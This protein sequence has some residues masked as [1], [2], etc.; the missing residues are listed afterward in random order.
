[1]RTHPLAARLL[2]GG[3]GILFLAGCGG[4]ERPPLG[5]VSG[6]VTMDG[7]PLGNVIVVMKP[8]NGRAAMVQADEQGHYDME[9][10]AGERG[11]K[12]GPTTVSFEWPLDY[13]APKPIPEKYSAIRS[14]E[15]I[16]VKEGENTFDFD[17]KSD[18]SSSAQTPAE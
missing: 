16:E 6:T 5:Y 8:D 2:V 13:A 17:L 10:V 9:Y 7:E 15:K 11:T 4:A 12:V 18:S 3:I 1:M 14:Q